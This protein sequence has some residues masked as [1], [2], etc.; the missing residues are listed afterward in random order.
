MRKEVVDSFIA[1][2][3][4]HQPLL[5]LPAVIDDSYMAFLHTRHTQT[6]SLILIHS[7]TLSHMTRQTPRHDA[8]PTF[9]HRRR[10]RIISQTRRRRGS[11]SRTLPSVLL[12]RPVSV[13]KS[14]GNF[15]LSVSG[16]RRR[17][18]SAPSLSSL[19]A[20]LGLKTAAADRPAR[21]DGTLGHS[22]R[23]ACLEI[24]FR[25]L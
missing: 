9:S 25:S 1:Q 8:C 10:R 12:H 11:T 21:L 3:D 6:L 16:P 13:T 23:L 14:H 24:D 5:L 7:L 2:F 18:L 17:S 22:A 4:A 20:R 19:V 15:S